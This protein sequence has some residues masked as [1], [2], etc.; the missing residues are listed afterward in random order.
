MKKRIFILIGATLA[1]MGILAGI[2]YQN[3]RKLI[4]E[5][6]AHIKA[7]LAAAP[8]DAYLSNYKDGVQRF[9]E[10]GELVPK[11]VYFVSPAKFQQ[12]E[13]YLIRVHPRHTTHETDGWVGLQ[14]DGNWFVKMP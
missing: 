3:V 4:A 6:E 2:R 13:T 1:V 9:M 11:A 8:S 5:K 10:T 14:K 7:R 12:L